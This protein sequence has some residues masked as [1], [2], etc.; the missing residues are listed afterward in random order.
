MRIEELKY[1]TKLWKGLEIISW[2]VFMFLL[3]TACSTIKNIPIKEQ[4]I[5]KVE[6][7]DSVRIKDS[8]VV[9]PIERIVD[10]VPDYDTLFLETTMAKAKSYIDTNYHVLKGS[11]ENKKGFQYKTVYKDRVI[12]KVDTIQILKEV[13]I[14]VEKEVKTYPK[15]YYFF[16]TTFILTLLIIF[17]KLFCK[18]KKII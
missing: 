10:I 5:T 6:I 8:T 9:I 1:N 17:L 12:E 14:P 7:R 3:I 11:I 4:T 2:L 16:L 18:F 15:S 13:P